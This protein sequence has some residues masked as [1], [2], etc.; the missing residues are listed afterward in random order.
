MKNLLKENS[1]KQVNN[2]AKYE[3]LLLEYRKETRETSLRKR[4]SDGEK[5]EQG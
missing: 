4:Q 1:V 5:Y 2:N 3:Q